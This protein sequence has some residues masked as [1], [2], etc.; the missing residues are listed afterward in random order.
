[1]KIESDIIKIPYTK[2]IST[3]YVEQELKK[4]GIVP[5]RWAVVDIKDNSLAVSV[6]VVR[7][8]SP[9]RRE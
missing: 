6:A 7:P 1:M 2:N 8:I 4:L 9:F 5:L 3:E